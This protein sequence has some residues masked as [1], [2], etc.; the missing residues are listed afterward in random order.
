MLTALPV[1]VSLK[2]EECGNE[3]LRIGG[4]NN[5]E[6]GISKVPY[7]SYSGN[8]PQC[9]AMMAVDNSLLIRLCL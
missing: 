4:M 1:I 8:C 7:F 3:I 5:A 6:R 9:G 2:C